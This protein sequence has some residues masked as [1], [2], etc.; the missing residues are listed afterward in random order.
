MGVPADPNEILSGDPIETLQIWLECHLNQFVKNNIDLRRIYF[1]PG[2]GFG[3]NSLQSLTLLKSIDAFFGF[4]VKILVGH[5][6]KSFMKNFADK[7]AGQRDYETLGVSMSLIQKGVDV[8]R[9]HNPEI[10][11]KAHRGWS[12]VTG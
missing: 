4:P 8:L 9:I 6:R 5:S 10:H 2:I 11:I 1:D 3:K 12:H 7:T